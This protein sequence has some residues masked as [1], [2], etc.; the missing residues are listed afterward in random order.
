MVQVRT[1]SY[2]NKWLGSIF[3]IG[4]DPPLQRQIPFQH[5][6][7]FVSGSPICSCNFSLEAGASILSYATKAHYTQFVAFSPEDRFILK[8]VYV[9]IELFTR[10]TLLLMTC[11]F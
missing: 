1:C 7:I 11:L 3:R 5:L 9:Q 2:V 8:V 4:V 6:A 10:V